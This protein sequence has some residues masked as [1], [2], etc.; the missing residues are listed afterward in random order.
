MNRR[1]ESRRRHNGEVICDGCGVQFTRLVAQQTGFTRLHGRT[2][3]KVFHD[4]ACMHANIGDLLRNIPRA[5]RRSRDIECPYCGAVAGGDC[6]VI[7]GKNAGRSVKKLHPV[8]RISR[9]SR[10]RTYE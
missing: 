6:K 8:R 1:T 5:E 4:K 2:Q 7:R 3:N 10:G 9:E